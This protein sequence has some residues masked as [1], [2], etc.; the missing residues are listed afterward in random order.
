MKEAGCHTKQPIRWRSARG[1]EGAAGWA[2]AAMSQTLSEA[3]RK[4]ARAAGLNKHPQEDRPSQPSAALT[5]SI[6]FRMQYYG[7]HAYSRAPLRPQEEVLI[8]SL[9]NTAPQGSWLRFGERT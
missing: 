6:A 2:D 4:A 3:P 5:V 8:M 7:G 9:V 1:L